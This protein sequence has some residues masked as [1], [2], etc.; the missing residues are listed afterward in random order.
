MEEF[1]YNAVAKMMTK[2]AN[3]RM[4]FSVEV[5]VWKDQKKVHF[6]NRKP[7]FDQGFQLA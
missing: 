2:R 5:P 7:W 3:C 6:K 1:D 4:R